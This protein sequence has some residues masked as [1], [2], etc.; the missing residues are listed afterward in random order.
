MCSGAINEFEKL[1]HPML[2]FLF[3]SL[4]PMAFQF[5]WPSIGMFVTS[6]KSANHSLHRTRPVR[7]GSL[8]SANLV[9]RAG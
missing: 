6:G 9:A 5:H 7:L 4:G 1:R 2:N 8:R 3:G